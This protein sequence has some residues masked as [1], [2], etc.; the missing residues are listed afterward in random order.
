MNGVIGMIG[1]ALKTELG[2]EQHEFVSSAKSSAESL[3]A[4][5]FASI[6]PNLRGKN[7]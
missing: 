7:S 3:L 4:L 5:R 6:H 1:L 2:H